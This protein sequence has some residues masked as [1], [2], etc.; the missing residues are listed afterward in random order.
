MC[1]V[2]MMVV[3]ILVASAMLAMANCGSCGVGKSSTA[4]KAAMDCKD[5]SLYACAHCKT[6]A[7]EAGKC[8]KCN[9]DMAKMRV[10]ECKDGAAKLCACASDCK[11]VID[12]KDAA[13]CSC[14]KGVV[15]VSVKGLKCCEGCKVPA[16]E[17]VSK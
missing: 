14:G 1:K 11:C 3:S 13:K 5:M 2:F 17:P 9:T 12:A 4:G 8:S 10:L 7:S 15:A 6:V 16:T